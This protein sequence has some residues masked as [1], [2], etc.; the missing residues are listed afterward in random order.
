MYLQLTQ[1]LYLRLTGIW[2][3]V[4]DQHPEQ[5]AR[6]EAKGTVEHTLLDDHAQTLAAHSFSTCCKSTAMLM[7]AL[8]AMTWSRTVNAFFKK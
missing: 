8:T 4:T 5:R 2:L 3:I 6:P 7:Q 1:F